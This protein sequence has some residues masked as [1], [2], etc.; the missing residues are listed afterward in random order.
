MNKTLVGYLFFQA[1][2]PSSYFV[3]PLAVAK[4]QLDS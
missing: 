4:Q 2:K 3:G 1:L